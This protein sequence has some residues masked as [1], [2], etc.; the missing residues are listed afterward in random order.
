MEIQVG[1]GN[2]ARHPSKAVIVNLFEGV[3]RPGGGTG[4]VHKALDGAVSQLSAG[5]GNTAR[6]S[7][8]SRGGRFR[9]MANM[10]PF[11]GTGRTRGAPVDRC[12]RAAVST[13]TGRSFIVR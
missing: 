6:A 1:K 11:T 3:K 12:S 5:G 8:G 7:R 10:T 4:A 13:G 2:L 9:R